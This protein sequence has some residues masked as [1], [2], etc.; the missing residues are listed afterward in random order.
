MVFY[1]VVVATSK[2]QFGGIPMPLV[3]VKYREGKVFFPKLLRQTIPDI[4]ARHLDCDD[5]NGSLVPEDIEVIVEH[6]G[7]NDLTEYDLMVYIEANDFLTRRLNLGERNKKIAAELS[8]YKPVS[9][10]NLSE[11]KAY[12]WTMLHPAAFEEF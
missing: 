9:V 8:N 2:L 5:P 11:V 7:D 1:C 4:V 10:Y 6:I 12:V 3:T